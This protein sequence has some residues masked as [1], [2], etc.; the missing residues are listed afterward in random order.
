MGPGGGRQSSPPPRSLSLNTI[1]Q[2]ETEV[3]GMAAHLADAQE[4]RAAFQAR[5][6]ELKG[7]IGASLQ[8][9]DEEEAADARGIAWSAVS[10][11]RAFAEREAA[12][13]PGS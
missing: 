7:V 5:I 4:R 12:L 11:A 8:S 10:R 3:L 2:A 13:R 1:H 6:A 9:L